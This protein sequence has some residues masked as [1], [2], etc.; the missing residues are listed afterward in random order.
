MT[1]YTFAFC[2]M[3]AIAGCDR[4]QQA[5][6]AKSAVPAVPTDSGEIR[7]PPDSPQLKRLRI[8][9]VGTEQV[10]LEEVF[11]PGKIEANPTRISRIALPVAGRVKQLMFTNG[12]TV[13]QGQPVIALDS[14][15]TAAALSAYRQAQAKVTQ[16]KAAQTKAEADLN[17]IKDLFDNRAVA[18]KEVIGAETALAQAKSDVAQAEAALEE[19]QKKLLIFG[20]QSDQTVQDILVRAPVSGKVLEISVA[21][22][23]YRN[24]TSAPVMTIADLST[25]FMAADV[26]EDRIRLIQPGEQVEINLSAYPGQ[27]LRGEVKRISDTVDPQTRTIKVR[28]EL[29]NPAGR[30]RPEMFG[31]IRH[32]QGMREMPVVPAGAI[33]QGDQR[34]IVYRENS[35]GVFEPVEVTFGRREGDRVPILSGIKPGDRVVIDGAMLLRNYCVSQAMLPLLLR[36]AFRQRFITITLTVVLIGL[37]IYSYRQLKIEAYPD[38]SDTQV[39]VITLF[40]GHAAE[41]M[42]QQVTV[43]IE[44]A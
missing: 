20:L 33:V 39:V 5:A 8:G 1:R 40:P 17:R 24:D 11:V 29:Q 31:E 14:P 22:G 13:S 12:R 21:A 37:G 16:A 9:E 44:R 10:P 36:A 23:E 34:N 18:Q 35:T 32:K 41:E 30:L 7:L 26:P 2:L 27:T 28:A 42:E 6:S 38:I 43:P 4:Q 19:T 25:V 15:E 3:F